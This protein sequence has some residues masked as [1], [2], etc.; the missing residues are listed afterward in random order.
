MLPSLIP[1][2]LNGKAGG[3]VDASWWNDLR[4]SLIEVYDLLSGGGSGFIESSHA[5]TANQ[6]AT[7][8]TGE[9]AVNTAFSSVEYYYE[10]IRGTTVF[11]NGVIRLQ[12][13]N[14]TWRLLQG[15]FEG[16]DFDGLPGGVTF[17]ITQSVNTVQLRLAA[18]SNGNG[19]I[20]FKRLNYAV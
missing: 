1:V 17:S 18:D 9:T 2:R 5:I 6:L 8:L 12:S 10:I 16:E 19:T 20:K 11:V 15:Q 3:N 7:N 13:V 14:G 4:T